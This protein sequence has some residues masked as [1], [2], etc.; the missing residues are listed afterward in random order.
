M[1]QQY[2]LKWSNHL[3][4]LSNV[5][6][7]LLEREALC[8]VILSVGVD[9]KIKVIIVKCRIASD[10]SIPNI[11]IFM[12]IIWHFIKAHQ[13]ILS[14]CSP[15]FESL[16]IE[17]THPFPIVHLSVDFDD[18]KAIIEYIYKGEVNIAHH[19]LQKFLKAA[20]DLQVKFLITNC[21]EFFNR[22]WIWQVKGLVDTNKIDY[23]P[24]NH[25]ETN[26]PKPSPIPQENDSN[27]E[28]SKSRERDDYGHRENYNNNDDYNY[29]KSSDSEPRL[30]DSVEGRPHHLDRKRRRKSPSCDNSLL[31]RHSFPPRHPSDSQVSYKQT[32]QFQF[33]YT[34]T[35]N[36]S[37]LISKKT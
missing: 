33:H 14:A 6:F 7:S 35:H 11:Y 12:R 32:L 16:F 5:F 25:S 31:S 21:N 8:D 20:N 36:R 1:D 27:F 37:L 28:D 24:E 10:I 29:R 18:L 4:N 34:Q 15:Y 2:C 26:S 19:S 13:T 9:Q 22:I 3:S 17:H 23:K 30:D